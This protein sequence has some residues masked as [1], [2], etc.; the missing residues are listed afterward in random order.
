[1]SQD[2]KEMLPYKEMLEKLQLRTRLVEQTE[3]N[4]F[5]YFFSRD[6]A[7]SFLTA[8]GGF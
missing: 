6:F 7:F 2:K 5:R 8:S 4:S 1:M 3:E